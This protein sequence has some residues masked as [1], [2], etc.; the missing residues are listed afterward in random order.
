[1]WFDGRLQRTERYALYGIPFLR[2]RLSRVIIFNSQE[3]TMSALLPFAEYQ[4]EQHARDT[5]AVADD[6]EQAGGG[7]GAAAAATDAEGDAL[8][9]AS[10]EARLEALEAGS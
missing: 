8:R 9:I 4:A 6:R 10:L 2:E 3:E 7:G 5:A 1:M